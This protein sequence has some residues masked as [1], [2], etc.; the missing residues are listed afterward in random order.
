MYGATERA[1]TG[2]II[3]SL[4]IVP[5][6]VLAINRPS[7]HV[8]PPPTASTAA[9]NRLPPSPYP[10]GLDQVLVRPAADLRER[11]YTSYTSLPLPVLNVHQQ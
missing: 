11:S 8:A 1:I 3:H 6:L 9:P 4:L 2:L 7:I 5:F 10:P